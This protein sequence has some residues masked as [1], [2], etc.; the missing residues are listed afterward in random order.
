M[1]YE[2]TVFAD[3]GRDSA[4]E[5]RRELKIL[6][7]ITGEKAQEKIVE[8]QIG[9]VFRGEFHEFYGKVKER[10]MRKMKAYD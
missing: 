9:A 4:E 5:I 1:K 6:E 7:E 10:I 8:G 3:I 2:I